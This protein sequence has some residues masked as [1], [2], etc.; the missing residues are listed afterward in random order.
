MCIVVRAVSVD[1]MMVAA[2]VECSSS[3]RISKSDEN[4]GMNRGHQLIVSDA[5][6]YKMSTNPRIHVLSPT[7]SHLYEKT[8]EY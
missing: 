2:L 5:L 4:C 1:L 6:E 3:K 7:V 8:I